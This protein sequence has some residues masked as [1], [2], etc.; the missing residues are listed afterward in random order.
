MKKR[1]NIEIIVKLNNASSHHVQEFAIQESLGNNQ[2]ALIKLSY[3]TSYKFYANM[4]DKPQLEDDQIV[5]KTI[6]DIVS[7][8][9][10]WQNEGL[11]K[12]IIHLNSPNTAYNLLNK[13][14]NT[15]KDYPFWSGYFFAEHWDN[16]NALKVFNNLSKNNP[17]NL[18]WQGNLLTKVGRFN[19]AL[20]PLVE[21]AKMEP[22]RYNHFSHLGNAY[23][24]LGIKYEAKIA[25]KKAISL[26]L[27]KENIGR[28]EHIH[29]VRSYHGLSRLGFNEYRLAEDKQQKEAIRT[30]TVSKHE[31]ERIKF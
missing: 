3:A 23:R 27:N 4:F 19:E 8:A 2:K 6:R 25:Y 22:N 12:T 7:E 14:G 18:H 28:V 13:V 11:G 17:V 10:F 9:N 21:V 29:L 26:I 30:G 31:L 20:I 16:K 1:K 15:I 24:G 5:E